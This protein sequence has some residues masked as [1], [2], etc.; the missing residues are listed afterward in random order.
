MCDSSD[1]S[2]LNGEK[3]AQLQQAITAFMQ[4]PFFNDI[5]IRIVTI[6]LARQHRNEEQILANKFLLAFFSLQIRELILNGVYSIDRNNGVL[7]NI[8]TIELHLGTIANAGQ[9]FRVILRYLYTG[10]LAFGTVHPF[11][12]LQVSRICQIP[13]VEIQVAELVK[14]FLSIQFDKSSCFTRQHNITIVNSSSTSLTKQ[15]HHASIPMKKEIEKS[16]KINVENDLM[17]NELL[18]ASSKESSS[19]GQTGN[20]ERFNEFVLPSS[21][22][23]GWCRNKKYIEQVANGYMCTVCHKVYGRYNSVSYHV[24]IYHRNSP[25][26][27]DEKGC[28]FRTREA[29]YIHFHKYYRHHIPLPDNID[30]GSRKCPFCRHVSKSPAMLEKHISRHVQD[31]DRATSAG[32]SQTHFLQYSKAIF[33]FQCS[34]CSY[35]GRTS[36]D[37]ERHKLFLHSKKLS[38]G[39]KLGLALNHKILLVDAVEAAEKIAEMKAVVS[40]TATAT[41][42][43]EAI[44]LATTKKSTNGLHKKEQELKEKLGT[45]I[46]KKNEE[47]KRKDIK[48]SKKIPRD[49]RN[50]VHSSAPLETLKCTPLEVNLK[51]KSDVIL[52]LPTIVVKSKWK[53]KVEEDDEDDTLFNIDPIMPDMDL[54]SLR[55]NNKTE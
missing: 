15:R 1:G 55:L 51:K 20:V 16:L 40:S 53:G 39:N 34:K 37:L 54:P 42:E 3:E 44:C 25:I 17:N 14:L 10:V 13:M 38:D 22:K 24:T 18:G 32:I 8:P 19:T 52:K 46:G 47:Q 27:C 9:A 30:L 2:G 4:P 7:Q 35:R 48:K 5:C 31:V 21:D 33:N 49:E 43:L 36:N 11:Q 6:D 50:S 45:L 29:R 41:A 28:S 26:K 12:V 23:E